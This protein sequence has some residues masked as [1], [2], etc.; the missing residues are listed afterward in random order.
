M[1]N[2]TVLIIVTAMA[3]LVLI[4]ACVLVRHKTRTK[5]ASTNQ[6]VLHDKKR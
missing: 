4:G 1:A 6:A 3:A 2:T 5:A